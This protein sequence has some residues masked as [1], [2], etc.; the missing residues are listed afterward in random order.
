MRTFCLCFHLQLQ[1]L[2]PLRRLESPEAFPSI[3]AI[4]YDLEKQLNSLKSF[5]FSQSI[6]ESQTSIISE[7]SLPQRKIDRKILRLLQ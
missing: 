5:N 3:S 1:Q 2:F 4:P 6:I 7:K